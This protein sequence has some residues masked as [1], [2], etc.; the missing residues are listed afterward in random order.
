MRSRTR[1]TGLGSEGGFTLVELLVVCSVGLIVMFAAMKM[2][3]AAAGSQPGSSSRASAVQ[4]ARSSMYNLTRELRNGYGVVT[5]APA[6]LVLLTYLQRSTCGGALVTTSTIQCR[7][8]YKCISASGGTYSCYRAETAPA[9]AATVNGK[10]IAAGL[11]SPNVFTY[12]P[13]PQ[14]SDYVAM[15]LAFPAQ[16]G[17][18]AITLNDGSTLRNSGGSS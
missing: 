14:A 2:F 6:K 5:A 13:T 18:D 3:T 11:S 8:T 9:V 4:Q 12:A 10:Q 1:R 7:V 15:T 17:D 16:E